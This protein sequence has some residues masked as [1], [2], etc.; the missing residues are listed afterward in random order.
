MTFKLD[1]QNDAFK[2]HPL[3]VSYVSGCVDQRRSILQW[4]KDVDTVYIP[5]NWGKRHWV[6]LVV[7]LIKGHINILDPF[8]DFTSVRK[9]VSYMSPLAQMLPNLIVSVCGPDRFSWPEDSFT[10]ARVPSITQ[11]K[12]GG[13]CGPLCIKF[14]EFH[15]HRL[16]EALSKLTPTQV[17]NLR[18]RYAIDIYETYVGSL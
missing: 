14:M 12:R 2:W 3:L 1:S 9:V 13:D 15:M 7:D 18:L 10:F 17:N 11:N 16:H 5:M 8:E 6:A 4:G